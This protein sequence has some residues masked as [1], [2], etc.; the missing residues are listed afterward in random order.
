MKLKDLRGKSKLR[1]LKSN[2][3]HYIPLFVS[4]SNRQEIQKLNCAVKRIKM[5][6]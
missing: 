6:N 3:L 1:D 5:F 2:G 4:E